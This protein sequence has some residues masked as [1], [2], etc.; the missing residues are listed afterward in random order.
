VATKADTVTLLLLDAASRDY[1]QA[2]RTALRAEVLDQLGLTEQDA[3]DQVAAA[4]S[5]AAEKQPA[6]SADDAG[7]TGDAPA[8]ATGAKG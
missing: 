5:K 2:E 6:E 1:T 3:T 8:K 7:D 4:R